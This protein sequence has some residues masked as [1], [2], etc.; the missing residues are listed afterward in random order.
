[1]V[2]NLKLGYYRFNIF[3]L[4][5]YIYF[6]VFLNICREKE[7]LEN[8]CIILYEDLILIWCKIILIF[9]RY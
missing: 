3:I 1:M 2:K 9:I 7:V 4:V 8:L 6:Y 5:K